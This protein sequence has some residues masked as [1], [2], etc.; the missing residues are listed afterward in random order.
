MAHWKW[1]A[2]DNKGQTLRGVRE[3]KEAALVL[4]YLRQQNLYPVS[5]RRSVLGKLIVRLNSRQAKSYWTKITRKISIL[6]EAGL[7]LLTILDIIGDK[8]TNT[9]RKNHWLR[10]K[11]AVLAGKDFS[12][13]LKEF[14]PQPGIFL[15]AMVKA[16]E[17]SGTLAECLL[18]AADQ[19]DEEYFLEQK[20]KTVLFYPLLLLGA[21]LLI[22]YFLS[23][24]VL[25]MYQ[26][27][28]ESFQAELP[29]ITELL[30]FIGESMPLWLGLVLIMI[31]LKQIWPGAPKAWI[32]PGTEK[33]RHYKDL[34]QFCALFGRL[35]KVGLPLIE[36]LELLEDTFDNN[37]E[38]SKIIGELKLAVKE[39]QR[40]SF[41]IGRCNYFPAEA[42]KMLEVAEEAGRLS[43]MLLYLAVMFGRELEEKIQRFNSRLEPV[44]IVGMAGIVGFVAIGVLLPIFD[45]STQIR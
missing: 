32:F 19:L 44:L 33:I 21:A 43:E 39:G 25:P 10:V 40:L 28:F 7:P 11:Q 38:L 2:L 22:I 6:L 20:I 24:V 35:L 23:I 34:R 8:E 14:A 17:K 9:S 27:I 3:E 18:E 16:G 4:K 41:V 15:E 1:K 37:G 36:T 30:F 5:I 31:L 29:L 26:S 42:I 13:G 12:W 45:V